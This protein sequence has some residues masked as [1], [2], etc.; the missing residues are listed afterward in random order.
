MISFY[1][2]QPVRTIAHRRA[3]SLRFMAA[4]AGDGLF[5][6]MANL[7]TPTTVDQN[8]YIFLT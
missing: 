4:K 3:F 5:I 8:C 7:V 1:L 6:E 2:L